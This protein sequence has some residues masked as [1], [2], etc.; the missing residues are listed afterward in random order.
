MLPFEMEG[1]Q[2][3]CF[4]RYAVYKGFGSVFS[5]G[6]TDNRLDN[7]KNENN[8]YEKNTNIFGDGVRDEYAFD[9]QNKSKRMELR[10]QLTSIIEYVG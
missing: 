3:C 2:I 1:I 5:D 8:S 4:F 10:C 7:N 9:Y 6:T